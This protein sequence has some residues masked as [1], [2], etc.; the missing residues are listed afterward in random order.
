[1]AIL[2]QKENSYVSYL[3]WYGKCGTTSANDIL[4]LA[5]LI[6]R[7]LRLMVILR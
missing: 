7:T 6:Q 4:D 3:G 2:Q 1:M 5:F